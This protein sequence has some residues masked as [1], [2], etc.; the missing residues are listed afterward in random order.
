[1]RAEYVD[2]VLQVVDLIP[3]GSV[4]S[5]GDIAELLG[6]GG[7][8]QV[9]SA[10]SAS[11]STTTWWRVLRASGHVPEGHTAAALTNFR[12]EGTPLLGAP[13]AL[14]DGGSGPW[15]VDMRSCR[16][17][18]D[19][20]TMDRIEHIARSLESRLHRMSV[21]DDEMEA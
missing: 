12:S 10:M 16:W 2:A 9:G 18:P 13:E 6:V 15:R 14:R 17:S 11:G 7:A 8:R 5:Y 21:A 1:M 4:L 20:S 3:P 19:D